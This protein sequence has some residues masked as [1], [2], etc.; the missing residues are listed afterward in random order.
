MLGELYAEIGEKE[1]AKDNLKIAEAEC[2][3]MGIEYWLERTR[4]AL[5]V[6]KG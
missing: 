4:K 6:L 5:A 1:K 3:D 2:A